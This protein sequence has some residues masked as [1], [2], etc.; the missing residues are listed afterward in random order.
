MGF[1][2][3]A[4][5]GVVPVAAIVPALLAGAYRHYTVGGPSLVS[6]FL[7][8]LVSLG[9]GLLPLLVLHCK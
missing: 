9:R 8:K 7:P 5:C 2:S 3:V 6:I 1:T 4:V